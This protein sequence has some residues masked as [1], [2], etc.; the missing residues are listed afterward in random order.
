M[1]NPTDGRV[2]RP[3]DMRPPMR[4]DPRSESLKRAEERTKQLRSQPRTGLPSDVM[5]LD[6]GLA[7]DGW[8]YQ[9]KRLSVYNQ[10]DK[11]SQIGNSAAGW[12]N[13]PSDRHPDVY[14]P[15]DCALMEKPKSMVDDARREMT[16][17]TKDE[18][19]SQRRMLQEAPIDTMNTPADRRAVKFTED[20]MRPMRVAEE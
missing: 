9:L 8:E 12:D 20:Y 18:L 5:K 15:P 16:Q 3:D 10:P 1:A 6:R 13:V 19:R 4:P 7:P 2:T 11:Q 14:I 17:A